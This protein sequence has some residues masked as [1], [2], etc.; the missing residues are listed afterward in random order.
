[1]RMPLIM[2]VSRDGFVCRDEN[3]VMSWTGP[4]DKA[5]FQLLTSAYPVM[6]AGSNTFELMKGKTFKGRELVRIS[7]RGYPAQL[8]YFTSTLSLF[9]M[10]YRP[11]CL[12]G[13]Q[14]VAL[15]ALKADYISDIYLC[16][17]DRKLFSGVQLDERLLHGPM[18]LAQEIKFGDVFV[19]KWE[20]QHYG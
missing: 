20:I 2:A 14:T 4:S 13:G 11:K 8:G 15:A 9:S 5:A 19:R 3:D 16:W 17:S 12:I 1:M 7:R 18:K 10:G 6:G